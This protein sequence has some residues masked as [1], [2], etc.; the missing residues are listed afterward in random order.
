MLVQAS[1][2]ALLI[3]CARCEIFSALVTLNKALHHEKTLASSLRMY[4]E[5]EKER[6]DKVLK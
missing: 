5:L 4:V 6:L 3:V 1:A 2:V